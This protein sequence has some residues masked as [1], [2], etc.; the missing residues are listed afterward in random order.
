MAY[1]EDE[2]L[3]KPPPQQGLP[4]PMEE[5][6]R[7][8]YL[9]EAPVVNVPMENS[10]GGGAPIA[11]A[12]IPLNQASNLSPLDIAT[13]K[14]D[15]QPEEPI[16]PPVSPPVPAPKA[17]VVE[18]LLAPKVEQAGNGDVA[19]RKDAVAAPQTKP[20]RFSRGGGDQIAKVENR[21]GKIAEGA[22]L[23]RNQVRALTGENPPPVKEDTSGL[24]D[25]YDQINDLNPLVWWNA[26]HKE[27]TV[28]PAGSVSRKLNALMNGDPEA[29]KRLHETAVQFAAE[30]RAKA[31]EEA[32]LARDKI[33]EEARIAREDQKEGAKAAAEREKREWDSKENDR[34]AERDHKNRMAES[35]AKSKETARAKQEVK[36]D[37]TKAQ[38]LDVEKRYQDYDQGPNGKFTDPVIQQRYEMERNRVRR[39]QKLVNPEYEGWKL[40][41]NE[42]KDTGL[43]SRYGARSAQHEKEFAL[44][45]R[46][47]A[48][49][50]L[51][52]MRKGTEMAGKL[53]T[54][55]E[56]NEYMNL[57]NPGSKPAP[58][59]EKRTWNDDEG[60]RQLVQGLGQK[61]DKPIAFSKETNP[62]SVVAQVKSL[63]PGTWFIDP[64]DGKPKQKVK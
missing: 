62:A 33:Q 56:I 54:E 30:Q 37:N 3:V 53:P 32:K 17:P 14:K 59:T 29:Y 7:A 50:E 12:P 40:E 15:V 44:R 47:D 22:S 8:G 1:P 48:I 28:N 11:A 43:E 58:K 39:E 20:D 24:K 13:G 41:R 63:P 60:A 35:E 51:I 9:D 27:A 45:Q 2:Y 34:R 18:G 23:D 10:T 57:M 6:Q 21:T 46:K 38:L 42:Q 25:T 55:D 31:S 4:L 64:R 36:D 61:P 5:E 16:P 26:V 49:N 52:S 19:A